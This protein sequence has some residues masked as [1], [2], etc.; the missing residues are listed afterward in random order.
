MAPAQL[1][2]RQGALAAP[3]RR[4]CSERA[5]A[6]RTRQQGLRNCPFLLHFAGA[7]AS[8]TTVAS[9]RDVLQLRG[10]RAVSIPQQG[11]PKHRK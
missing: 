4:A 1:P 6:E 9:I 7:G 5:A 11:P 8:L 3:T 2:L 10:Y